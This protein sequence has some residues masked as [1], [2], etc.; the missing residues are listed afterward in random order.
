MRI[1]DCAVLVG[2]WHLCAFDEYGGHVVDGVDVFE[3]VA[4]YGH[5]VGILA[6]L[7]RA[8]GVGDSAYLGRDC[9]GGGAVLLENKPRRDICQ[10]AVAKVFPVML[11]NR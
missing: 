3:G 10:H 7:E 2:H 6:R 4:A 11:A 9:G 1:S 5:E 8:G